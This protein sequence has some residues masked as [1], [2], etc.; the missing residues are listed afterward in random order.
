MQLTHAI[1]NKGFSGRASVSLASKFVSGDRNAAPI[2]LTGHSV[3][4]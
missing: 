1:T 4:R 3:K 2:S